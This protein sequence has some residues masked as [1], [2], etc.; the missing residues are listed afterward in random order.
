MEYCPLYSHS[1]LHYIACYI[2]LE[3]NEI[4][5]NMRANIKKSLLYC[6]T[7]DNVDSFDKL[8]FVCTTK[9]N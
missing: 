5:E 9:R 7:S 1:L 3:K 6:I 8:R 4:N 2:T